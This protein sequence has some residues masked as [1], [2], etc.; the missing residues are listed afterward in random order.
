M[1]SVNLIA[2]IFKIKLCTFKKCLVYKPYKHILYNI[3]ESINKI[4]K[5][6]QELVK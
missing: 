1:S 4:Y 5:N 3:P 6:L 2:Q